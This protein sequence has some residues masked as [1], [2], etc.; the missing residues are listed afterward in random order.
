MRWCR[1]RFFVATQDA[2]G[3]RIALPEYIDDAMADLAMVFHWG[4]AEM[5]PMEIEELMDWRERA[6]R[7][8]EP[9]KNSRK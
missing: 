6:R 8:A 4:P 3:Q 7:R 5:A 9:P 1:G 2:R